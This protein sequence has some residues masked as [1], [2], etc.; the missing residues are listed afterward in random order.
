MS[1]DRIRVNERSSKVVTF[2]ILDDAGLPVP[3]SAIS[4]AT[5]TLY[6]FQTGQ[7]GGSPQ[8]GILNN[9]Q[10]QDVLNAND[11]TIDSAGLVTWI[12]QPEDNIIS[13]ERRQIERHRAMFSFTWSIGS[14]TIAGA[15]TYECEIEVVNLRKAA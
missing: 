14:P 6:D 9:R 10:D 15:S 1:I 2:T 13:T 3:V 4:V 5:L 8:V 12:M 7:I 11:V